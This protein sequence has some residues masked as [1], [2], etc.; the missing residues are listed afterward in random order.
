MS[1]PHQQ[2]L[3]AHMSIAG[4][5]HLA[6][7]RIQSLEGTA[8]QIFTKNQRQ[9][10][11]KPLTRDDIT[12]FKDRWAAWGAH[13]IG[14]HDTYLINLAAPDEIIRGKS[15]GAFSEE[16]TR[17]EMLSIPYLITHP[18]SSLEHGREKGLAT[19]TAS[20]DRAIEE[21]GTEASLVLLE[22]TAG[23][24]TNLGSDFDQL[25]WIIGRSR[26][27]ERLGVCFDTC[28]AFGAGY[29]LRSEEGY[30]ATFEQFDRII[31]LSRLRF[32]HLNDTKGGLD[33]RKD[34]H[35]HIGKGHLG[36][37][38]F[39]RLLNDPRFLAVPK[40]LETPKEKDLAEDRENLRV[41]RSLISW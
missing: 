15:I 9:W 21:S 6:I 31:G 2:P 1:D 13:P 34:R 39:R 30:A 28:H 4:G 37:E 11:S 10:K 29:D 12:L 7:E 16:L 19:F 36:L 5:L 35:E 27:P 14:A 25:A 38:P 8:L 22:N 3:G 32:F 18:G 20:L 24:G 33:S 41:L 17:T 26:H 23:Q 40:V